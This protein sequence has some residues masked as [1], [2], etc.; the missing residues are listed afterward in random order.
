MKL[1][2]ENFCLKSVL[3]AFQT[4]NNLAKF[5]QNLGPTSCT[6]QEEFTKVLQE[7]GLSHIN[8][9]QVAQV[10]TMMASSGASNVASDV[11][12]QHLG[13]S[14]GPINLEQGIISS[15]AGKN[16]FSPNETNSIFKMFFFF[17][18]LISMYRKSTNYSAF[19]CLNKNANL[20]DFATP[21]FVRREP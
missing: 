6:T 13:S 18:F 15:R 10:L 17:L 3:V 11:Q 16:V 4:E 8:A 21:K 14:W 20:P 7:F 12:L 19:K 1:I 9:A 2:G 5:I